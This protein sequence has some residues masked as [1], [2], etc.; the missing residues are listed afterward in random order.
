MRQKVDDNIPVRLKIER[1]S[2]VYFPIAVSPRA[3]YKLIIWQRGGA[4]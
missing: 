4:D 2:A 3:K 1:W